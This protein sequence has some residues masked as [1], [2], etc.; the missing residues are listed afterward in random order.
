MHA[1]AILP[2]MPR[3]VQIGRSTARPTVRGASVPGRKRQSETPR[4][5]PNELVALRELKGLRAADVARQAQISQ[6]YYS[7]LEN[8]TRPI[9]PKIAA[10]LSPVLGVTRERLL[11]EDS[12][13]LIPVRVIIAAQDSEETLAPG[14]FDEPIAWEPAPRRLIDPEECFA[15]QLEDD[16]AD[17]DGHLAG[18]VFFVRPIE[19]LRQPLRLRSKVVVRFLLTPIDGL[20]RPAATQEVLYGVL[21]RNPLGDL[22]LLTLSSNPLIGHSRLIQRGSAWLRTLD[23]RI[24]DALPQA[25][26]VDYKPG[27]GDPAVILGIVEMAT[28][29]A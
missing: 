17:R 14:I 7:M 27:P 13:P 19:A 4:P 11:G 3:V 18:T 28:G 2:D 16:S 20:G 9:N 25:E 15:A 29:P 24:R 1:D 5:F 21:N 6:S 8:E 22:E 23:E 26:T 12:R 10:K